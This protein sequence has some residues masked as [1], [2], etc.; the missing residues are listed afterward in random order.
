M[1]NSKLYYL[2]FFAVTVFLFFQSS[3]TGAGK[4]GKTSNFDWPQFR[5]PNRD[6]ISAET[7]ILKKWPEDGPELLWRRELGDGYSGISI[8]EGYL[9]T[10][11]SGD[12]YEY[13]ICFDAENGL[14]VWQFVTDNNFLGN[15]GVGPRST[16]TVN[17]SLVYVLS[18]RGKLYALKTTEKEKVWEMDLSEK[19]GSKAP[20][21]G[22]STSPLIEGERLL[23]EVGGAER[24]TLVAFDKKTGAVEWTAYSDVKPYGY[25]H[26]TG[27]DYP[28]YSSPLAITCCD[29]RQILFL[30]SSQLIALSP[31]GEVLWRYPWETR[32]GANVITP[33]YVPQDKIFISAGYE[34]GAALLDVK[35]QS[36]SPRIEEIWRS[37]VMRNHFSTPVLHE[38]YLYGF[39]NE[40]LKCVNVKSGEEKWKKGGLGFGNLILADNHLIILSERGKLILAQATP[41]KYTQVASAQVLTGKCWTSPSLANGKLYLRNQYEIV[42]FDLKK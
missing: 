13:A 10:M 24:N 6:G 19:F 32:Y 4:N 36:D 22:F 23:L 34:Q 27:R 37:K 18:A 1:K 35:H 28:A 2:I 8:C 39:D 21:W 26:W 5:G 12:D 42:C 31:D 3:V 41:L 11:F 16:P 25:T 40:T 7:D 9:Y 20:R 30:T 15:K 29:R 33:V 14:L 38:N 17:D